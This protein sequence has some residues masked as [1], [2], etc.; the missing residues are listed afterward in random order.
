MDSWAEVVSCKSTSSAVQYMYRSRRPFHKHAHPRN[1]HNDTVMCFAAVEDDPE[2]PPEGVPRD[3]PQ[4]PVA[5]VESD[6]QQRARSVAELAN[7]PESSNSKKAKAAAAKKARKERA[8][9]ER[10]KKATRSAR[11]TRG[12]TRVV[13]TSEGPEII[14][15]GIPVSYEEALAQYVGQTFEGTMFVD[16]GLPTVTTQGASTSMAPPQLPTSWG[17]PPAQR[18]LISGTTLTIPPVTAVTNAGPARPISA[19]R[20][21]YLVQVRTQVH[22]RELLQNKSEKDIKHSFQVQISQ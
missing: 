8:D 20:T 15:P 18:S 7:V 11:V 9:A 6:E 1:K 3:E 5:P 13:Q 4:R 10:S 21:E 19:S 16:M 12:S 22:N 14:P 17:G 2:E